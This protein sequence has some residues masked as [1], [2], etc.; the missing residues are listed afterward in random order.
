[1]P[2]FEVVLI[3]GL[4][5]KFGPHVSNPVASFAFADLFAS[6]EEGVVY[7]I[8]PSRLWQDSARTVAV[9][10]DG[11]PVGCIDD[12][13][14]NANHALQVASGKRPLYRTDGTLHWLV[15]DGINDWLATAAIDLT[16][17]TIVHAWVG[18]E[19]GAA[20]SVQQ[21]F[22]FGDNP[23]VTP[24]AFGLYRNSATN[25]IFVGCRGSTGTQS[26]GYTAGITGASVVHARFDLDAALPDVFEVENNGEAQA[27]TLGAGDAAGGL[28]NLPL[29]II[30]NGLEGFVSSDKFFGLVVRAGDAT[31]LENEA[32]TALMA[33]RS[34]VTLP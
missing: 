23:I 13:S 17:Q 22:A 32:A 33:Q 26:T 2:D 9:T 28:G 27:L 10:A 11:Q 19:R 14:G 18:T 8:H 1:M 4:S 30:S 24:G 29:Y 12:E 25:D 34:G 6:G 7:D 20:T 3:D 21:I 31:A 5:A 16:G 15:G